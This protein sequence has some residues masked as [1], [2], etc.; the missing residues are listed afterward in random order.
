MSTAVPSSSGASWA[1]F[2]DFSKFIIADRVGM[3]IELIPQIFAGNTAGGLSYPTGQRG[4]FAWWRNSS[5]V[6]SSNAFR[7]GTQS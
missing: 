5:D 3:S 4:L 7:A 2:G 6:M 1:L